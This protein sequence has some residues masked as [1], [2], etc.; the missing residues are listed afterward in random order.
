MQREEGP[1]A[2]LRNMLGELIG[3]HLE[4]FVSVCEP[5]GRERSQSWSVRLVVSTQCLSRRLLS[6]DRVTCLQRLNLGDRLERETA[7]SKHISAERKTAYYNGKGL[8]ILGGLLLGFIAA[9]GI[10]VAFS[11]NSLK[12][13]VVQGTVVHGTYRRHCMV[14][15]ADTVGASPPEGGTPTGPFP[16]SKRSATNPHPGFATRLPLQSQRETGHV[17]YGLQFPRAAHLGI[18]MRWPRCMGATAHQELYLS[19]EL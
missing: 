18:V 14:P 9:F 4:N 1:C 16:C 11:T 19:Q 8:K 17:C 3:D 13:N 6:H 10:W 7:M 2:L 12:Q 5:S 15:T